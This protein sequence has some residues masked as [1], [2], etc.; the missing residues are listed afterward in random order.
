MDCV[1]VKFNFLAHNIAQPKTKGTLPRESAPAPAS[2]IQEAVI[3]GYSAKGKDV[4]SLQLHFGLSNKTNHYKIDFT[5]C[6]KGLFI[7]PK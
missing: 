3:L 6:T 5:W 2:N 1:A 7:R 4:V